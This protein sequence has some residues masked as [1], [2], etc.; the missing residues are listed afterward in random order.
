MVAPD[1]LRRERKGESLAKA[2]LSPDFIA[3]RTRPMIGRPVAHCGRRPCVTEVPPAGRTPTVT[4]GAPDAPAQPVIV[5][6]GEPFLLRHQ[7]D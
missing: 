4:F 3:A 2:R 1:G 5:Q 6:P 7:L